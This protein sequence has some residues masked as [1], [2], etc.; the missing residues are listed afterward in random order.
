MTL[1]KGYDAEYDYWSPCLKII[2]DT[3]K[4]IWKA[5]AVK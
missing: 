5:Y 3:S 4:S 1:P 2:V